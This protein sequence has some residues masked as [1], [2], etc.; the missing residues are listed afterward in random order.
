MVAS[1]SHSDWSP[2]ARRLLGA[3]DDEA[4]WLESFDA[5]TRVYRAARIVSDRLEAC[6][7]ISPR[8]DLPTRNW[9]S[10]LFGRPT[11]DEA[12]RAGL[13]AGR[14]SDPRGDT[15][16]VVCSCFGVGCNTICEAIRREGL[17]T[18]E[19]IGRKLRAGTNCGS[20]IPELSGLLDATRELSVAV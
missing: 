6:V 5:G 18:V 2:W 12:D 3:S 17:D 10:S 13:L 11:L 1:R 4:D 20:C 7:F 9:L 16:T 19:A 15:G 14:P 8:P